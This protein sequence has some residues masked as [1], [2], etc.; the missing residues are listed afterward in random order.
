M[1]LRMIVAFVLCGAL[2]TGLVVTSNRAAAASD[3]AFPTVGNA[4]P[5]MSALL[6][7]SDEMSLATNAAQ[8]GDGKPPNL[9]AWGQKVLMYVQQH[10]DDPEA[11]GAFPAYMIHNYL[12]WCWEMDR[13]SEG[14][15]I[16]QMKRSTNSSLR[17]LASGRERLVD[18]RT[19]PWRVKFTPLDGPDVDF[20]N[21]S[22]KV[23][24]VDG[25]SINCPSCVEAMSEI[26]R[27]RDKYRDA[28][29]EVIGINFA[30]DAKRD[31][32]KSLSVIK[33][34]GVDWPMWMLED[35]AAKK[36]MDRY[37]I[38]GFPETWLFDRAGRL[39]S[40]R[41]LHGALMEQ[42][43]RR[44]LGA[45]SLHGSSETSEKSTRPDREPGG[46]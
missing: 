32:G 45:A 22:G 9:L 6:R 46:E 10:P 20:A 43:I 31:E 12:F 37:G 15:L 40:T 29:F 23:V 21:F 4:E 17:M 39:I 35:D 42:Q 8:A 26:K 16:E 18:L 28:G 41:G 24:L 30:E 7:W 14:S 11:A 2:L 33:E 36:F 19:H 25:W 44:A 1:R 38:V 27:L 3:K 34:K 13:D 5:E